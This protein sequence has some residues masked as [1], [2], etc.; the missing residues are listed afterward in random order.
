[1][2]TFDKAWVRWSF[3]AALTLVSAL[4]NLALRPLLDGRAPMLPFF[5]ALVAIGFLAGLWPAVASLCVSALVMATW[6]I[7]PIGTPWVI[8]EPA[9]AILLAIFLLT[10]SL[11]VAAAS[12]ARRWLEG[13]R[14][15]RRRL[16]MTLSV[17]RMTTWEWD[18]ASGR[19]TLA[20]GAEA[21][22]GA[23]W[24]KIE[25]AWPLMHEDDRARV[26]ALM[27]GALHGTAAHYSFLSRCVRPATGEVR[28][29]ETHGQV[30]RNAKGEARRVTGVTID[31]DERQRALDAS[32][33]AEERFAI[34]LRG[35][36]I[37]VWECDAQ[38]R[39]T[40]VRNL[41]PGFAPADF[42][43]RRLG[44]LVPRNQSAAY[45]EAGERVF[46]T[47]LSE[48]LPVRV[49]HDGSTRHYL[50]TID[51][52]KDA[53]GAIC[54]L[55]GAS[56][57]ITAIHA[58][59]EAL[60]REVERKDNFLATLAHELRNPMAPIRYAA[61]MLRQDVP[62]ARQ[63]HAR[64]VIERQ[65]AHMSRLLDDLLDMSR[66]TRNA[67]DLQRTRIDLRSVVAQAVETTQAAFAEREHRLAVSLPD[68]PVWVHG[69][70]TR[71][72]QVLGNLL[73]NAAKYT[74]PGG[75]VSVSVQREG[76]QAA[77][78]VRDSGEGLPAEALA[79]VFDLFSRVP[80]K[81]GNDPGGLGIGLA[82]VKQLVEL[83]GGSVR[84]DSAGP[85]KGATF[86]VRLPLDLRPAAQG[87]GTAAAPAVV[88]LGRGCA[89]LVVDDNVDAADMLAS[90]LRLDGY[91]VS[92]AYDGETALQ[93]QASMHPAAVL[94]DIGLPDLSGHEVARR[95]RQAPG[96]PPRLIAISGWGQARDLELTREAGFDA[97]LVKPAEPVRVRETLQ[98]LLAPG[99]GAAAG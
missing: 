15:T 48:T 58:A 54:G 41:Q 20:P 56:M 76:T 86:S 31:V 52:K 49:D 73:D 7:E 87:A 44:E 64:E 91:A 95:M 9:N 3:A 13:Y 63:A 84:A 59:Q 60:Q 67:I 14:R 69:D 71:L 38:L 79:T 46:A 45:Q 78:S 80:H 25:G 39:Y 21:V 11:A 26:S 55:I 68:E 42:I 17:G 66:I 70:A 1:M 33:A 65:S 93:A 85:G 83:H 96:T 4:A 27:H 16:D 82:V 22:F 8:D 94:L 89:V 35:S 88:P 72:L 47:G 37:V 10:G 90:A 28:W 23:R 32:R 36:G 12:A 50:A 75:D 61:A 98:A 6:S 51:A 74:A 40:W 57:E 29:I 24:D 30:M 92:V 81:H 43:G 19:V 34:A 97:H 62:A 5:P 2:P 99:R 77:I 18:V 53:H